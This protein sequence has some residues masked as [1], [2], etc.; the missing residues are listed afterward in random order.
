MMAAHIAWR[1]VRRAAVNLWRAPLPSLVSVLTIGLALFLGASFAVGVL[2]ARR[3]LQGWG[4][5]PSV[6]VYLD[7]ATTDDEARALA[8]RILDTEHAANVRYVDRAQALQRLRTELGDL[9]SALD[10]LPE[11]P[12]P[13]SL[14]VVPASSPGPSEIRALASRLGKLSHVVEVDY[15]REWLDRIEAL[16]RAM[17]NFGSGALAL[18]LAAALLVV[19]NTI[20]LAVYARRDEIEIMKLVGATDRYVRTPFL[21]EGMLQGLAGAILAVAGLEAVQQLVIPRAAAAFS[22]AA[23]AAAPHLVVAHFAI[24]AGAGAVVGLLG[25]YLAVA[26]FLR[27]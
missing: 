23:G 11:N 15:G 2:S 17:R 18:V 24:L 14:E 8:G 1:L 3:L 25:S 6:T 21:L 12:L 27:A 7:R 10:G 9:G 13:P 16:G 19:A 20:R 4:A 22:F 5:Q 26:R